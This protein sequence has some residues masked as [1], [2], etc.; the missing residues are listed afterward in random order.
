MTDIY[1][2]VNTLISIFIYFSL[3]IVIFRCIDRNKVVLWLMNIYLSGALI[4]ILCGLFIIKPYNI[5]YGILS[6][7]LFTFA[8]Y[9]YILGIFGLI[10]SSVRIKLL[11]LINK[12]QKNGV[13]EKE[14]LKIINRDI[15]VRSRLKKLITSGD[16]KKED[17]YI[18][19]KRKFSYFNLNWFMTSVIK[20]IYSSDH[21]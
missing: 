20:K 10:D 1:I 19:R 21:E 13:S 2:L 9:I 5:Y 11:L 16:L 3:H 6:F 7:I 18:S 12:Y 4:N 8:V 14:I 15:I 17:D